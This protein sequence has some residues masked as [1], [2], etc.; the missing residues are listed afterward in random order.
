MFRYKNQNRVLNIG[1]FLLMVFLT[2]CYPD[3]PY[4]L[5]NQDIIVTDY[6]PN[7]NFGAAKTFAM[8]DSILYLPAS[9]NET[10]DRIYDKHILS[11]I[12]ANMTARGYVLVDTSQVYDLALV[13]TMIRVDNSGWVYYP[14]GWWGYY[15]W[16]YWGVAVPYT[17]SI[18][19]LHMSLLDKAHLDK[20]NRI[21][22]MTWVGAINGLVSGLEST[23][24]AKIS[25]GIDQAFIQSPY[26]KSF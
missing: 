21:I 11:E 2:S 26:I 22:P 15:G 9:K 1:S 20:P 24:E 18:G 17:F 12:K 7:F 4:E 25:N 13:V 23:N 5:Y 14:Y 3:E 10:A 6:N 8:A 19:T 16:G